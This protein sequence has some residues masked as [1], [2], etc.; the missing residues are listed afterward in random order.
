[1]RRSLIVLCVVFTWLS[2]ASC[3]PVEVESPPGSDSTRPSQTAAELPEVTNLPAQEIPQDTPEPVLPT[4]TADPAIPTDAATQA[5]TPALYSEEN[6]QDFPEAVLVLEQRLQSLGYRETGLVDGVYDRQT[7]LAVMHLQWVNQL[8]MTGEVTSELFDQIKQGQVDPIAWPPP[9]PASPQ[10][11]FGTPIIQDGFLTGRL[12][13]LGYLDANDPDFNPIRFDASTDLAVRQFEALNGLNED[14]V[15]DF[16]FWQKLFSPSAVQASGESP[17][18]IPESEILD[19]TFFAT[20][21]D[22]IDLVFDGRFLWVLHSSGED[23]FDN[24]LLRIDPS[25]G[26]LEQYPPIMIGDWDSPDNRVVQMLHDGK[27]LWFLLPHSGSDP[28]LVSLIPG[29]GEKFIHTNFVSCDSGCFPAFALGFDGITLWATVQD[30][31]WAINRNTGKGYRSYFAGWSS[32]GEMAFDG[33]CM[34]FAGE[35]GI[36]A[37]HTGGDYPCPGREAAYVLPPGP[38][39]FDGRR[40]WVADAAYGQLFWL[41]TKSGLIGEPVSVGGYPSALTFDGEILWVANQGDNTV[42]GVDV[43]TGSLGPALQA[44]QQ[45]VALV[46]DGGQLWVVNAGDQTLQAIDV[47]DYQIEIR[48]P[49]ATPTSQASPTPTKPVFERNLFLT[50]PRLQGDDVAVLQTRLLALGYEM[51]GTADG[52]FGPMTDEAVRLFQDRNGLVVDGVV[53]P[54]TWEALFS[55]APVG[56]A[57]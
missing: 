3:S 39:V 4:A 18:T 36:A 33:K 12:V 2:L 44:G 25:A 6:A 55:S 10:S 5:P 43:D 23:L 40:I 45:P 30:Q 14:G 49:T 50:S 13:D 15:V 48:Q 41:D 51:V 9:F 34:W 56:P 38:V 16:N 27:R 46:H 24:L 35:V 29:T 32:S 11:Q 37:F 17:L 19:S 1:M 54:L 31:A 26:V 53:G 47:Q 28:E 20:L 21:E 42:Q 22:P 7:K 8:P 57:P 52:V